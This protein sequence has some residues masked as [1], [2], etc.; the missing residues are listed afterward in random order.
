MLRHNTQEGDEVEEI[1]LSANLG[2]CKLGV[3]NLDIKGPIIL[4][5]C[6]L[7]SSRDLCVPASTSVHGAI[8]MLFTGRWQRHRGLPPLEDMTPRR[9]VLLQQD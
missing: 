4:F 9:A 8:L 2:R 6:Q 7:M 1:A 3:S 5:C